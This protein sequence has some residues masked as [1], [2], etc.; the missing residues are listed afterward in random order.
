MAGE[1]DLDNS[2]LEHAR[3]GLDE[4]ERSRPFDVD[5]G[6]PLLIGELRAWLQDDRQWTGAFRHQWV[7]LLDDCAFAH[8]HLGDNLARNL[9]QTDGAWVELKGCRAALNNS[10]THRAPDP[11]IRRRLERATHA[12]QSALLDPGVLSAIWND[13]VEANDF[14]TARAE[15]TTTVAFR[16][17]PRARS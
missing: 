1:T 2:R 16:R 14:Q 3:F 7:S 8:A 17:C 11:A 5:P 12:I 4:A 15:S 9:S 10:K 13:L 6:I